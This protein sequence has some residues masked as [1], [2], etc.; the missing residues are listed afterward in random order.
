MPARAH[1][2]VSPSM[3]PKYAARSAGRGV[4]GYRIC[5]HGGAGE[6][7]RGGRQGPRRMFAAPP[8]HEKKGKPHKVT[9]IF[10]YP[11]LSACFAYKI[12]YYYHILDS[13]YA[14]FAE[15]AVRHGRSR[16]YL[17]LAH[18]RMRV[19]KVEQRRRVTISRLEQYRCGGI[20]WR[21]GVWTLTGDSR[22]FHRTICW[23]ERRCGR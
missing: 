7:G 17:H 5:L 2:R 9:H 14:P 3:L 10:T 15:C 21:R 12:H 8:P 18:P 13:K 22:P 1:R 23:S 16:I 11:S 4:S 20:K 6:R 19:Q